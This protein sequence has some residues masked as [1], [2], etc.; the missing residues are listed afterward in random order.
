LGQGLAAGGL[1]VR[2]LKLKGKKERGDRISDPFTVTAASSAGVGQKSG[3][4]SSR[5]RKRRVNQKQEDTYKE[6]DLKK[7]R[8]G[9][10]LSP[11]GRVGVGGLGWTKK[12]KMRSSGMAKFEK[13]KAIIQSKNSYGRLPRSGGG[14]N[15]SKRPLTNHN[16][17]PNSIIQKT[18][19]A[20]FLEKEGS[21]STGHLVSPDGAL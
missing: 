6:A 1:G 9:G 19:R 5:D 8:E 20:P 17:H 10:T 15:E 13:G 14:P 18:E 3:G 16:K 21:V 7:E 11:V 4:N 2:L 12:K